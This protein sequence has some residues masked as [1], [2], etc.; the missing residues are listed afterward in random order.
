LE[1]I[2]GIGKNTAEQLLKEFRS[3]KRI[4]ELSME[5]L[6]AAVGNAKAN[7]IFEFFNKRN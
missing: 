3:V 2:K 1:Q 7:L 4:K 5:E 6:T